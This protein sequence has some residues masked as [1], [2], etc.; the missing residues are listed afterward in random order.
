MT[1]EPGDTLREI[2]GDPIDV[3][4]DAQALADG[5]LVDTAS[6]GITFR[7]RVV[8]RAT[9]AVLDLLMGDKDE[10]DLAGFLADA[11][12]SAKLE[13]GVWQVPPGLWLEENEVGGW[14]LMRPEDH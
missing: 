12:P 14:T 3:Y 4:T 13:G 5:V 8:N 2:F 11:L 6:L 1:P 7:R 10:C 9:H